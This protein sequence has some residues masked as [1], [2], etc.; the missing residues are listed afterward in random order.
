MNDKDIKTKDFSCEL[1]TVMY[2]IA[3]V[4]NGI[5]MYSGS[6]IP[7]EVQGGWNSILDDVVNDIDVI[8]KTLYP[9]D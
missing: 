5:L 8:N 7:D 6:D 9:S 2:K 1:Q 3:A 4:S